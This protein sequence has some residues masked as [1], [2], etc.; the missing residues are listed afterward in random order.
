[1]PIICFSFLGNRGVIVFSSVFDSLRDSGWISDWLCSENNSLQQSL[2][3][4]CLL[5]IG[6]VSKTTDAQPAGVP[7]KLVRS[8]GSLGML[9]A[10]HPKI[11][12]IGIASWLEKAHVSKHESIL[13]F[14]PGLKGHV[15]KKGSSSCRFCEISKS[16]HKLYVLL[17]CDVEVNF[18][19]AEVRY[20]E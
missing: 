14:F 12:G 9:L 6:F 10:V 1:M 3:Q 8:S 17:V 7:R 20:V 19:N 4:D 11:P 5:H 18:A 13:P 16:H 2:P 15:P